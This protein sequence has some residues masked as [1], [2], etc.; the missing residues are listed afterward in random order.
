MSSDILDTFNKIMFFTG[1]GFS[2]TAGCKVSGEMLKELEKLSNETDS[3]FTN[4][5][6]KTIKFILSCLEYHARWRSLETN[7]KYYYTPNI[8]EFA[9]L[10]RR[11]KNRENLLPYPITGNWSDKIVQ[12]EREFI[13]ENQNSELDLYDSIETKIKTKC[14]PDWLEIKNS[15][16]TS[17]LDPIANF[18]RDNPNSY[19]KLD[20][21]T[22]NNDLVLENYFHAEN[23]LYNGFISEKWVGFNSKDKE[24]ENTLNVSR[25][26][27]YKLHGSID[28]VRRTD[29]IIYNNFNINDG[30][31]NKD[32][33][34]SKT[35]P[36]L[37]FGHGTKL[38]TVDPFFSL[39]HLFHYKVSEKKYFFIIGYSFFDPHINNIIFNELMSNPEQNKKMVIINPNLIEGDWYYDEYSFKILQNTSNIEL[40]NFFQDIQKNT[41][42]SDM[43]EFN[44][45]KISPNS[46]IY[47]NATAE[48]FISEMFVKCNGKY[49]IINFIQDLEKESSKNFFE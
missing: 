26:N 8:E 18:F 5:E 3:Y 30:M 46:F 40:V 23:A 44:I 37:I 32:D 11:I 25:I 2:K 17:Y 35:N 38:F 4:I 19:T 13:N 49:G 6:K 7:G 47:I 43:P 31:I 24:Q 34:D 36:F 41:F 16:Q 21:F 27:Y 12:L 9:L 45:S 29:G 10:L 42:Y 15:E 22:L 48:D 1:A 33:I 14:Y 20:W 39:L 28:W